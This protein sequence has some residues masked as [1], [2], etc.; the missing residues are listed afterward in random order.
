MKVRLV[1]GEWSEPMGYYRLTATVLDA[2]KKSLGF[3]F[4][5]GLYIRH[6][7]GRYEII[8]ARQKNFLRT[9]HLILHELGHWLL[10]LIPVLPHK[11]YDIGWF[12]MRNFFERFRGKKK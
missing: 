11:S 4:A 2:N 3:I 5:S 12:E 8:V 10:D 1:E 9:T 6:D 7:D